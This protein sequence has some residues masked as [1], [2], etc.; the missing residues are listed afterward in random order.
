M[1]KLFYDDTAYSA[2]VNSGKDMN[3]QLVAVFD[4][5]L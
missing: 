1:E 5:N 3:Y 2:I 4:V